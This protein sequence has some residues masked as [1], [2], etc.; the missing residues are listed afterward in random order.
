MICIG[1]ILAVFMALIQSALFPSISLFAFAPFIALACIYTPFRVAIWLAVLAGFCN[2]LV[3][4]DF[5]GIHAV[6]SALVCT[7]VHRFRLGIF[8]DL[9]LQLCFYSALISVFTIIFELTI[10]FLFDRRISIAGKSLFLD[11]VEM[12]LINAGYAF[13]WFVGPLLLWEWAISQW[14]RWR[15]QTNATS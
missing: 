13:F 14:K 3:S 9:P 7:L 12:P 10:L 6:S 5:L 1:F 15:A 8:K 2:D 11:F 4:S